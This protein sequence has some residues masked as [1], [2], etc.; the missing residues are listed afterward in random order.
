MFAN[1]QSSTASASVSLQYSVNSVLEFHNTK[2][3][4][5]KNTQSSF[6]TL[7]IALQQEYV[8]PSILKIDETPV[9]W[10]VVFSIDTSASMTDACADSRTKMSHIIHTLS[11][12]LRVF[13]IKTIISINVFIQSFNNNTKTVLDFTEIN[14]N[15]VQ[16]LIH[17]VEKMYPEGQTDITKPLIKCKQLYKERKSQFP[18]HKFIHIMLTDGE[19]NVNSPNKIND[20]YFDYNNRYDYKSVFVGFGIQHDSELLTSLASNKNNEYYFVDKLENSAFVY[21]EIIHNILE[22]QYESVKIHVVNGKIYNWK[23]N[24]WVSE[25]VVG[26]L[27][28][29]KM[30]TFHIQSDNPKIVVGTIYGKHIKSLHKNVVLLEEISALPDLTTIDSNS[31][32]P[33]DL[34]PYIFRQKVQELLYDCMKH[35]KYS[36]EPNV[37]LKSKICEFFKT[38]KQHVNAIKE[39]KSVFWNMLL[40][41]I[42]IL[43]KTI[44]TP[45]GFVFSYSRYV[46]QG[47]ERSYSVTNI[48]DLLDSIREMAYN[49]C[50][51][52]YNDIRMRHDAQSLYSYKTLKT[53]TLSRDYT[54]DYS[55]VHLDFDIDSEYKSEIHENNKYHVGYLEDENEIYEEIIT[56]YNE[57]D[58]EIHHELSGN[59]DSPYMTQNM[60]SIMCAVSS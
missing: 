26:E 16:S 37:I 29:N 49:E 45:Y 21:G 58:D 46:S 55:M 20:I 19:D 53:S 22:L 1:T 24:E 41:D 10:D 14:E 28:T 4:E 47:L 9:T 48:N 23:T 50:H 17:L 35:S 40:D 34:T 3:P 38:M 59:I 57:E 54:Q 32:M 30:R 56:D 15:N 5:W 43:Y 33:V 31:I 42:F 39:P 7:N 13:S 18:H 52:F 8:S 11:N 44:N 25:M 36:R 2:Y 60:H 6:G 12:I 27:Y 51:P